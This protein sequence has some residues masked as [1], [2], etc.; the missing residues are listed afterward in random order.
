L[1]TPPI[2]LVA[3]GCGLLRHPQVP[4]FNRQFHRLGNNF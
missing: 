1:L 3:F 2:S 4:L